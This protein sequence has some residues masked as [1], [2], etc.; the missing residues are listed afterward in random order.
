MKNL[1]INA[2][3]QI[4]SFVSIIVVSCMIATSSIYSVTKL[5]DETIKDTFIFD[6]Y[7]CFLIVMVNAVVSNYY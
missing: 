7:N 3:L 6:F 1:S 2:K 4:A 5:S